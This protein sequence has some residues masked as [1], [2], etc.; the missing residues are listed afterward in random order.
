MDQVDYLNAL[1]PVSNSLMT[2]SKAEDR[3]PEPLAKQFLSLLMA[4]AYAL[5]TRIDLGV[6][7]VALQRIAHEPC[8]IHLRRLSALVRWAQ[9]HPLQLK[10]SKMQCGKMLEV[11][12]DAGFPQGNQ[13]RRR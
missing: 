2:G 4:L 3:L 8:F 13:G 1:K 9:K 10:Y 5:Q 12:S 6:Y 7:V 11:H